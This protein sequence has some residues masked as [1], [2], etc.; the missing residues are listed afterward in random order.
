M[1]RVAIV[2][3]LVAVV[4]LG[5]GCLGLAGWLINRVAGDRPASVE[6]VHA[7]QGELFSFF[8]DI[9]DNSTDKA[10]ERTSKDYR[11]KNS[12]EQ[13]QAWVARYPQLKAEKAT[14]K[15]RD[16]GKARSVRFDVT[17]ANV[18]FAVTMVKEGD[19]WVV[20]TLAAG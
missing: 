3:T 15:A 19:E 2:G 7:A 18:K 5:L 13:F 14:I 11:G 8:E 12:L 6:A 10:Y 9:Q 17:L 4:F 1:T 16:G 20:D